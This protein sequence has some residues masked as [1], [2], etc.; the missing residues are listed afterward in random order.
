MARTTHVL[1]ENDVVLIDAVES[2]DLQADGPPDLGLELA[3]SGGFLVQEAIHDA[4]VRVLWKRTRRRPMV[5]PL[6]TEL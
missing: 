1:D 4:V 6:L 5:I 3:Q 2:L